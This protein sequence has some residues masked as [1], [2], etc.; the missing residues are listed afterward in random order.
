MT[1]PQPAALE[2]VLPGLRLAFFELM[3]PAFRWIES[4]WIRESNGQYQLFAETTATQDKKKLDRFNYLVRE[5]LDEEEKVLDELAPDLKHKIE[6]TI[7]YG[8]SVPRDGGY[9][10]L[11]SDRV[12]KKIA[13]RF[14]PWRLENGQ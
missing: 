10:E 2:E 11:M 1:E 4:L 9:Q 12:F 13:K 7:Q 14:A 3:W 6:H 5:V 8:P